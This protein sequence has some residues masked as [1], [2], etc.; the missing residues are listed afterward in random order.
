MYR[1]RTPPS[2]TGR[3]RWAALSLA[4]LGASGARADRA[5]LPWLG[6]AHS[7]K[8]DTTRAQVNAKCEGCHVEE[9]QQWRGS[10]HQNAFKDP[11]FQRAYTLEPLAFCRGCHAPEADPAKAPAPELAEL[12]VACT[13]CHVEAGSVV[14]ASRVSGR[15]PHPV[16][17]DP[18]LATRNACARCHEF[19]FPTLPGV[20]M[21]STLSEH[22]LST[23]N[24]RECQSCHMP[25]DPRTNKRTHDFSV[26]KSPQMIRS[27]V[28]VSASRW[29]ATSIEVTLR[30]GNIGHAFPTGDLFR[31]LELRACVDRGGREVCA[32]PAHLGRK[33]RVQ[34]T[35]QG[36]LRI[37]I[38]DTRVAAPGTAPPSTVRLPFD[39]DIEGLPVRWSVVYQRADDAMAKLFSLDQKTDEITVSSGVLAARA[40]N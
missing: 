11:L 6:P 33:Y 29:N 16:K 10:L 28:Q 31:R 32:P 4:L 39:F 3:L 22:R 17:A 26:L 27:G 25:L 20:A 8:S 36:T 35:A 2:P 23:A 24:N 1:P 9:A 21:Q 13:T 7:A 14:T 37:P 18:A 30:P 12:G 40:T 38:A 5:S 19:Q 15:S 34:T